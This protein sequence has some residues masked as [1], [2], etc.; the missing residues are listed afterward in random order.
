MECGIHFRKFRKLERKEID[1]E[2]DFGL[3][4]SRNVEN[5]KDI[6]K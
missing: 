5:I 6:E 3:A 1:E 4:V 2:I